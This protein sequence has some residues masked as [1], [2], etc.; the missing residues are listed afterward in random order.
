MASSEVAI[1][2]AAV[3]LKT[4]LLEH[5]GVYSEGNLSG[6]RLGEGHGATVLLRPVKGL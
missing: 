3:K 4:S 1:K 5:T 2:T 6:C